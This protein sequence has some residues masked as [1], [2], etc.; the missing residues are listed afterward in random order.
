MKKPALVY[1]YNVFSPPGNSQE[2]N[3]FIFNPFYLLIHKA[4]LFKNLKHQINE[5][6]H[7]GEGHSSCTW[8]AATQMDDKRDS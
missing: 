3:A 6:Q 7:K 5:F 1:K 8:V 4:S 2:L